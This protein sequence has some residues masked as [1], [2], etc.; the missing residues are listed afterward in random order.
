MRTLKITALII[1]AATALCCVS[2]GNKSSSSENDT[3]ITGRWSIEDEGA[4][5][6]YIFD[7]NG[8]ASVYYKPENTYFEDGEFFF[9][10]THVGGDRLKYDGDILTAEIMEKNVITLDRVG[11]PAPSDF[12]GDY[13]VTGGTML[14]SIIKSLGFDGTDKPEIHFR[15]ED[16]KAIVV[17]VDAMDYV[18]DGTRLELKGKHG[19]P[20]S[21]GEAERSGDTLRIKRSDGGERVLNK[22]K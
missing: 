11:E 5:G 15:V 19:F 2:C 14:D 10:G 7:N 8:T 21:D 3:N 12:N 1:A 16:N 4:E 22:V 9:F 20:S 6:G 17:A 13:I 18:Y